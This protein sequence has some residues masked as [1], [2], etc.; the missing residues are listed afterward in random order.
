MMSIRDFER[1]SREADAVGLRLEVVRG[2]VTVEASPVVRHQRA[3]DR[4]RASVQNAA[5]GDSTCG[6]VHLADVQIRFPDGSR[7]R[8]DVAIF[9]RE[10]DEQDTE[11]TL[12]PEAVIE[13]LS[14]DYEAKDLV[15]GV[16]FYQ[17]VGVRDIIVLDPETGAVRHWQQGHGEQ[18]Y[19]SPVNL[20]LLCGCTCTV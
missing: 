13:V 8:P 3:V 7:K 4:I 19:T 15:I 12:L 5:I 18:T 14:R 11:V 16:P 17:Q 10:P 6:C 1:I 9:C 2:I 20:T